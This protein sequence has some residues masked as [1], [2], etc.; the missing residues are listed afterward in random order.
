MRFA[1]NW[2][3]SILLLLLQSLLISLSASAV[4]GGASEKKA[5]VEEVKARLDKARTPVERTMIHIQISDI[6]LRDVKDNVSLNDAKTLT[7]R[8]EEYRAAIS[9][10]RE[11]ILSSGRDP[12]TAPG[13][14]KELEMLL[15]QHITW[16]HSWKRKAADSKPI[17]DSL[18][19]ANS[20]QKE[21]LD[22]LFPVIGDK[23]KR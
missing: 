5:S 21:M 10:A 19:M 20:I 4:I 1:A 3:S 15:R 9:M 14:Y 16:L 11:T 22:L 23:P 12:T 6:L 8:L 17:E 2:K 13:G 18:V 7:D